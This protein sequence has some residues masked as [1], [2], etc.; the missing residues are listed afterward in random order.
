MCVCVYLPGGRRWAA[1]CS[2]RGISGRWTWR[3]VCWGTAAAVSS[4]TENTERDPREWTTDWVQ[5][6]EKTEKKH[7]QQVQMVYSNNVTCKLKKKKNWIALCHQICTQEWWKNVLGRLMHLW[8][9]VSSLQTQ[10]ILAQPP[11]LTRML[12]LQCSAQLTAASFSKMTS[13]ATLACF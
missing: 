6:I 11:T 4:A 3:E 8:C 7:Y 2:C 12:F 13:F 1:F 5:N 9:T 10:F